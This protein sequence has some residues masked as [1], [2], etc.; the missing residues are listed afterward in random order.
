M[1]E[2]AVV[3]LPNAGKSSLLN[4]LLSR[5]VAAVSGASLLSLLSRYTTKKEYIHFLRK[6]AVWAFSGFKQE[7]YNAAKPPRRGV[8]RERGGA[9]LLLRHPRVRGL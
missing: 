5:K 3:G 8:R 6:E 2:V 4:S 9:D 1:A 7:K